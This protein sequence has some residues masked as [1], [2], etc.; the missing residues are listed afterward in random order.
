MPISEY[1][2]ALDDDS[3]EAVDRAVA[4]RREMPDEHYRERV[5]TL[6]DV[7]GDIPTD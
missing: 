7:L 4:E 3:A 2:G 1:Y 5:S 6:A